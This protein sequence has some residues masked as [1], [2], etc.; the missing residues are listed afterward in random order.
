M[1]S[2]VTIAS[3][4]GGAGKTTIARLLLR[5][6]LRCGYRAAA[7]DSDLNQAL[8][9]WIRRFSVPVDV[10]KGIDET[11][12]I[13]TVRELEAGQDLVVVDTAGTAAQATVFAIGA[14]DLVLV[15]LKLSDGDML[16]AVKTMALIRS[17]STM[18]RREIPAR[19]VLTGF[20]PNALVAKHVVQEIERMG[21]QETRTRLH[22]LVGYIDMTHSGIVPVGSA[23]DAQAS[24]LFHEALELMG[25]APATMPIAVGA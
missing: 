20:K 14:A 11:G 3:S 16:E 2:T 5:H 8:T 7:I 10:R 12:I 23:V 15:P 17:T 22:D 21:L 6:A 25:I 9:N 4:K 24:A 1:A 18:M 19:L 13:P